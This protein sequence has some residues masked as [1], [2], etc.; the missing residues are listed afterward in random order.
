MD[1]WTPCFFCGHPRSDHEWGWVHNFQEGTKRWALMCKRYVPSLEKDNVDPCVCEFK[2]DRRGMS[3]Q[4][5]KILD[6]LEHIEFPK[7]DHGELL[8]ALEDADAEWA[9][10]VSA[11]EDFFINYTQVF[12]NDRSH[13]RLTGITD[14]GP[15]HRP[16]SG[17]RPSPPSKVWRFLYWVVAVP[18]RLFKAIAKGI[19][20]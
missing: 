13:G 20:W 14:G 15:P 9:K 2:E 10:R 7:K 1:D 17:G 6:P 11:R 19:K 12:G 5:D 3:A 16:L 8:K 18:Y 4:I